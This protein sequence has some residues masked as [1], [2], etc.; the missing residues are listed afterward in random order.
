[1]ILYNE[2]IHHHV[3]A[4]N[5]SAQSAVSLLLSLLS[6]C[7]TRIRKYWNGISGRS[8]LSIRLDEVDL[9]QKILEIAHSVP[10]CFGQKFL[11]HVHF[12]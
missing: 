9:D 2:D 8:H 11:C 7:V 5:L 12:I 10:S 6:P 3:S 4:G 1:M